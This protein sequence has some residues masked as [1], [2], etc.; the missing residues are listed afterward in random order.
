MSCWEIFS[1]RHSAGQ[2]DYYEYETTGAEATTGGGTTGTGTGSGTT[3]E[4]TTTE[5]TTT[6]PGTGGGGGGGGGTGSGSSGTSS[7]TGETIREFIIFNFTNKQI[8]NLIQF[9]LRS[10]LC[11]QYCCSYFFLWFIRTMRC[12]PL[13]LLNKSSST[14]LHLT[15]LM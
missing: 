6:D 1:C 15:T 12:R 13:N 11:C 5:A 7:A 3:S 14:L 4:L 10:W 9:L 2:Y 8:F